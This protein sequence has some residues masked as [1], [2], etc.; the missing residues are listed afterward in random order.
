MHAR[1]I[2]GPLGK[3][4]GGV[5]LR[6][7][8][9]AAAGVLAGLAV[10]AV[11]LAVAT[12]GGDESGGDQAASRERETTPGGADTAGDEEPATRRGECSTDPGGDVASA[13][14]EPIAEADADQADIV[15]YCVDFTADH[16]VFAVRLADEADPRGDPDWFG[17]HHLMWSVVT[18][19]DQ[20]N[21]DTVAT[22]DFAT[23]APY[24]VR[25]FLD[26]ED[27]AELDSV[28]EHPQPG[29]GE[30][31]CHGDAGYEDGWVVSSFPVGGES[32]CFAGETQLAVKVGASFDTSD[33]DAH[34]D[35]AP[36]DETYYRGFFHR[37]ADDDRDIDPGTDEEVARKV[38]EPLEFIDHGGRYWAVLWVGEYDDPALDEVRDAVDQRWGPVWSDGDIG[39]NQGAAETLGV[40][41]DTRA[42]AVH[43]ATEGDAYD[44]ADHAGLQVA[45][46]GLAQVTTYCLD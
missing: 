44:F 12:A 13:T 32:A 8:M 20:L 45:P 37:D 30:L 9:V 2:V 33:G 3:D 23:P 27:G 14:G 18:S 10:A 28:L 36:D 31:I 42:V 4:L 7:V 38:P 34:L 29:Q 35:H 41:S 15:D 11:A 16:A 19:G 17:I 39:C 6:T 5:G 40:G 43:F 21:D 46:T 25:V 24:A 26:S 1:T 22:Q